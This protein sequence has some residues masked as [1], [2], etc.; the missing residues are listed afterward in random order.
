[1]TELIH[2]NN[3]NRH[4]NKAANNNND[5]TVITPPPPKLFTYNDLPLA[6]H[7]NL[8]EQFK[9]HDK[10]TGRLL[11]F[12]KSYNEINRAYA[13]SLKRLATSNL[14]LEEQED[15]QNVRGMYS[16]LRALIKNE[17][18]QV[19]NLVDAMNIDVIQP[20]KKM[21]E[22]NGNQ[23]DSAITEINKLL[24]A[25]EKDKRSYLSNAR[26]TEKAIDARKMAII[27][28]VD[29][30][31][32]MD[33]Q[34]QRLHLQKVQ[35]QKKLLKQLQSQQKLSGVGNNNNN[36]R[37][38]D[39]VDEEGGGERGE[40]NGNDDDNG[41]NSNNN[42]T[43]EVSSTSFSTIQPPRRQRRGTV[44]TAKIEED[45]KANKKNK[46]KTW[47]LPPWMRNK[48]IVLSEDEV[49]RLKKKGHG[50]GIRP[51]A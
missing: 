21:K 27:K 11:T 46:N 48:H 20:V 15:N 50:R 38:D 7:Q 4:L 42:N 3:S 26:K 19:L 16:R 5:D 28:Q 43:K 24:N 40:E 12:L 8:K 47:S 6:A 44:T 23:H 18:V 51:S 31:R 32:K 39:E 29:M 35:Q 41:S 30:E 36:Y 10:S 13:Q 25:L 49:N 34:E 2:N 37:N 14:S 9:A 1:M 17:S 45:D 33:Q 22:K